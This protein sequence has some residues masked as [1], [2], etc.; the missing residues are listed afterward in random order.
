MSFFQLGQHKDLVSVSEEP[1]LTAMQ[2]CLRHQ[3]SELNSPLTRILQKG[4][5][6]HN[7][8]FQFNRT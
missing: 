4:L 5:A 8:A 3:N 6:P 7:Y 1:V 2:R